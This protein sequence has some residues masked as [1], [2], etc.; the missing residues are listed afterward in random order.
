MDRGKSLGLALVF[1]LL[2]SL[3]F[4]QAAAQEEDVLIQGGP[5]L[6]ST[7]GLTILPDGLLVVANVFAGRMSVVDPQTGEV[8]RVYGPELGIEMPD[9]L[10]A[11]P[12][13]TLYITGEGPAGGVYRLSTN[14]DIA[15]IAELPFAN[16][17]NLSPDGR[18]FMAQC[19][20]PDNGIYEID[21]NGTSEPRL[22]VGGFPGCAVN[23]FDFGPD[24]A[25]YAPS[26]FTGQVLRIDPESGKVS[27]AA[28]GFVVPAAVEFDSQ[29]RMHVAD[30]GTGEVT[31]VNLETGEREVLAALNVGLDNLVFDAQDNLYVSS[32]ADGFVL[33]VAPDGT[34]DTVVEGGMVGPSG[35]AVRGDRL[36]EVE[37]QAIRVYDRRTGEL[38]KATRSAF[39]V[40][41]I[42]NP[43]TVSVEPMG[44]LVL[45]SWFDNSVRIWNPIR[46][47]AEAVLSDF[48]VPVNGLGFGDS[49]IVAELGSGSVVRAS[50]PDYANREPLIA[51][52]VPAGLATGNGALYAGDWATGEI[53]QLAENEEYLAEPRLVGSGFAAPEGLAVLPTGQLAVVETGTGNLMMLDPATGEKTR[54]AEGL[55]IEPA[56][57]PPPPGAVP[58]SWF[59][60][61]A[62]AEDGTLY[63]SG[64]MGNRIYEIA[65][66]EMPLTSLD[67]LLGTWQLTGTEHAS[68]LPAPFQTTFNADGTFVGQIVGRTEPEDTATYTFTDGL[69]EYLTSVRNPE[70]AQ[71]NY[72]PLALEF[73]ETVVGMHFV[74]VGE[75]CYPDRVELSEGHT[76]IPVT[77]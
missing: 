54:L 1:V 38:M 41:E 25:I 49:L 68:V 43:I 62:A 31:R 47:E 48:A 56:I 29:G 72:Q 40:S 45:T 19:F 57:V 51:L 24:G 7:N 60:G 16:P 67:E 5:M 11:A 71:A 46:D 70:C 34:V 20:G 44:N 42:G 8:V 64:H 18:L 23:A 33:R 36:Y 28:E 76:Y 65:P 77:P 22:I 26:F 55:S 14:G 74:L 15:K 69:I 39:S 6:G 35:V 59:D 2:A 66:T 12:D 30:Q 21:P 61:V 73:G 52:T 32:A 3:L 27:T 9:D 37:P 4:G 10:V 50:G 63:V 75:D 17:I 53:W 13:G 58:S